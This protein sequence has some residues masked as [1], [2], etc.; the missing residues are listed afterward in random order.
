MSLFDDDGQPPIV[1]DKL[2]ALFEVSHDSG[3]GSHPAV[4]FAPEHRAPVEAFPDVKK[5]SCSQSSQATDIGPQYVGPR[6]LHGRASSL[7]ALLDADSSKPVGQASGHG[8]AA[9]VAAHS[10]TRQFRLF[11]EDSSDA[12]RASIGRALHDNAAD[13]DPAGT[14]RA[15]VPVR[16]IAEHVWT[17]F[18]AS[19]FFPKLMARVDEFC[20]EELARCSPPAVRARRP[21]VSWQAHGTGRQQAHTAEELAE[22]FLQ[23][24]EEADAAAH[25][26]LDFLE[27]CVDACR[28]CSVFSTPPPWWVRHGLE[29]GR[30]AAQPRGA[31][32]SASSLGDSTVRSISPGASLGGLSAEAP[33]PPRAAFKPPSLPQQQP[34]IEMQPKQTGASTSA[35]TTSTTGSLTGTLHT[36]RRVSAQQSSCGSPVFAAVSQVAPG[37]DPLSSLL[38]PSVQHTTLGSTRPRRRSRSN[39]LTQRMLSA[40]RRRHGS[41]SSPNA[42]VTSASAN[43]SPASR[44]L[45]GTNHHPSKSA[46][47]ARRMSMS[48]VPTRKASFVTVEHLLSGGGA[49]APAHPRRPEKGMA[50]TLRTYKPPQEVLMFAR[51]KL[52][53]IV[54]ANLHDALLGGTEAD[55]AADQAFERRRASLQWLSSEQLQLPAE[56]DNDVILSMAQ[57]EL[58]KINSVVTPEEKMQCVFAAAGVLFKALNMMVRSK[59]SSKGASADDFLPVFIAVVL[60]AQVPRLESN[61]R[62]VE[63]FRHQSA[64]LAKGGYTF[65]NLRSAMMFLMQCSAEDVG[66]SQEEWTAHFKDTA[67]A[68]A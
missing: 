10:G 1:T 43:T 59:N 32:L 37:T 62:F 47:D 68:Q 11:S 8:D 56:A 42:P 49:S 24:S 36:I 30:M 22:T 67:S 38:P 65:V 16:E 44:W 41:G 28:T 51:N 7:R 6:K 50:D 23:P 14:V 54:M 53:G 35:A 58:G 29:H 48:V 40:P 34:P 3:G 63:R 55:I 13:F 57:S 21:Q 60:R 31:K 12:A 2:S 27:E 64:M 5:D 19:K 25:R 66:V 18:E 4:L 33:P 15:S 26:I 46:S 61:C 17:S 9:S 39:S 45:P 20:T 52:E